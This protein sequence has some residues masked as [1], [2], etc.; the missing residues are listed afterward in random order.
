[1]KFNSVMHV[2]F[3]TDHFDEMLDFYC[4]KLGLK[5][6]VIVRWKEYKGRTYRPTM[7][8]LAETDP[9][10]VFY[11]YIEIAPGQFVELFP[12]S[13]NQLPHTEW[14]QHVGYSHFALLVDDIFETKKQLLEAGVELDTDVSKGPSG[15][16]QLWIHDPDGNKFEVMQY[17][18]DSWQVIGHLD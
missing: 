18:E 12:A 3:Y 13:V 9:E 17:T 10:G 14:N 5:Q 8:K 7:A 11:T 16:Y 6:K 15:T 1:M 2:S 4:N